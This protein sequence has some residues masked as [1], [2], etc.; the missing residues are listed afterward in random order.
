MNEKIL[1]GFVI[2]YLDLF[3]S[4]FETDE[5]EFSYSEMDEYIVCAA[6]MEIRYGR[7]NIINSVNERIN[8]LT[9]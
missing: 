9:F 4:K 6:Y 2:N 8:N 3:E 1:K 5:N 7:E